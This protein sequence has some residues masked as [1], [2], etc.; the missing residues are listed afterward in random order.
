MLQ[1]GFAPDSSDYDGRTALM[2]ASGKGHREVALM[3]LGANADPNLKDSLGGNALMEASKHGHDDI[4]ELLQS[5]GAMCGPS[6][7]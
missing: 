4:I 1:Q 3:L 2:L 6:T 5:K 7:F